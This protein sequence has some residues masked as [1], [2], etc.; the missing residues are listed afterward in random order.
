[1]S[2]LVAA[3]D[4]VPGAGSTHEPVTS[5]VVDVDDSVDFS[6][7]YLAGRVGEMR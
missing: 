4:E 3:L 2:E 6:G 7:G 5:L 1:M